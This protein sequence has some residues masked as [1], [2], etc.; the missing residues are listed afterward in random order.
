M[1]IPP[2]VVFSPG[3][4]NFCV[5]TIGAFTIVVNCSKK[6]GLVGSPQVIS[7]SLGLFPLLSFTSSVV[8]HY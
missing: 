4:P 3:F 7:V 6:S 8:E 2:T 5:L 1:F